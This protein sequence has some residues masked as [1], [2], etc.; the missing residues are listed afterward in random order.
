MM[1]TK[2]QAAVRVGELE[3]V[4]PERPTVFPVGRFGPG[5][6]CLAWS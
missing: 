6:A 3:Q 5:A 1:E 4:H 2:G